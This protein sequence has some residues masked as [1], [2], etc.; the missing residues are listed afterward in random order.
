MNTNI[1]VIGDIHFKI[2]NIPESYE[3]IK[4]IDEYIKENC[5]KIDYIIVLGDILHT[6]EKVHT[7]ALNIALEFFKILVKYK[8]EKVYVLVG[9]HDMTTNT[10][11]LNEGHWMNC[12]K[13]WNNIK[14]VDKVI[15]INI[16]KN[17]DDYLTLCPYVPDGRLIEALNTMKDKDWKNSTLI[18]C[19]QLLNGAKMG[20]IKAENIEEWEI[21][22]PLC[23]S[24]HIHDKQWVKDNLYYTGSSRQIAYGEGEDKTISLVIINEEIE[25]KEINLELPTKKIVYMDVEDIE[26]KIEK[27]NIKKNEEIKLVISGDETYFK[28]YKKTEKLKKILE[29]KGIKKIVFKKKDL[30]IEKSNE[31]NKEEGDILVYH[32]ETKNDFLE[33]LDFMI[34]EEKDDEL[35]NLYKNIVYNE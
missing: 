31:E 1:L 22:Y 20:A 29:L 27:L 21:E 23:I 35:Y 7:Q 24:G 3:F 13:E 34:K 9:N 32:K 5:D 4:K 2:D 8:K 11:F 10:N 25:I 12:L 26:T 30:K 16:D 6:H 14:V 28:E 33:L 19:H 18:L 17:G 15:N